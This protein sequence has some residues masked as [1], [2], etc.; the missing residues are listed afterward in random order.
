MSVIY[1][2]FL[3]F[4]TSLLVFC[5]VNVIAIHT[6]VFCLDLSVCCRIIM[7][8]FYMSSVMRL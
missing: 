4:L 7:L 1:A 5:D 3:Y 2:M 6:D 8:N